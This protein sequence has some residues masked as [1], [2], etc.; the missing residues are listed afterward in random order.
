MGE[1][2]MNEFG[3]VTKHLNCGMDTEISK[4]PSHSE[5]SIDA[6][7]CCQN[8]YELLQSDVEQ[9]H[10]AVQLSPVQLIFITAFSQVFIF[11]SEPIPANTYSLHLSSPPLIKQDFAILYQT[12]LI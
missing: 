4:I 1:E 8:L 11:G 5:R 3:W 12:F 7:D 6:I 9:S 10:K 2:T